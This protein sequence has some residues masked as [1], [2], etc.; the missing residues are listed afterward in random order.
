MKVPVISGS[1]QHQIQRA[2]YVE[3]GAIRCELGE[4]GQVH[5]SDGSFLQQVWMPSDI[6]RG[7]LLNENR[8]SVA[9]LAE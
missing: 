5:E 3:I 9:R 2:H 7:P 8:S 4:L 1:L 6:G